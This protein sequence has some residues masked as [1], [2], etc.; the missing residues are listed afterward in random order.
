MNIGFG[1]TF[2]HLYTAFECRAF[3][4]GAQPPHLGRACGKWRLRENW[5]SCLFKRLVLD[6]LP[7]GRMRSAGLITAWVL[8]DLRLHGDGEPESSTHVGARQ[9][10]EAPSPQAKEKH[11]EGEM[12]SVASYCQWITVKFFRR[13]LRWFSNP[14]GSKAVLCVSDNIPESCGCLCGAVAGILLVLICSL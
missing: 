13:D 2:Q 1:C 7:A 3:R 8:P 6:C 10:S 11:E 5:L 12:Y 4:F 9:G 14:S